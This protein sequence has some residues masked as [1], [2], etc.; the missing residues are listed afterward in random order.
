MK[1]YIINKCLILKKKIPE[2]TQTADDEIKK[3]L[4]IRY[5]IDEIKPYSKEFLPLVI[6]IE[7]EKIN[8]NK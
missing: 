8:H 6:E 3:R 5:I 7:K 1:I 2:I 4:V